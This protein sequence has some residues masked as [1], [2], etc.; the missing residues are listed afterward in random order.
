VKYSDLTL[1]A[2]LKGDALEIRDAK[3]SSGSGSLT[4]KGRIRLAGAGDPGLDVE[5]HPSSFIAIRT[6]DYRS[7]LSGNLHLGGTLRHPV[8][9]GAITF[10]DTDVYLT[11]AKTED[12]TAA[13]SVT[14]TPADYRMLEEAF[15]Y[16]VAKAPLPAQLF[17]DASQLDV[18]VVLG[19]N[20]WVRQRVAP[21]LAIQLTGSFQLTKAPNGEPLLVGRIAPVPGRGSVEQFARQFDLAGG[22]ILLNGDLNSHVLDVK[23]EY[24]VPSG[25]EETRSKV[26]V[27]LD[28]QGRLDQ[29]KLILSSEPP[30]DQ[31]DIISYI[32]T[33]QTAFSGGKSQGNKSSDAA[34]F[35][36]QV[37]MSGVTSRIED[38]AQQKV[39]VDVVE[40]RQDGVEGVTLIAGQYVTPE[41]YVG[42]RQPVGSTSSTTNKNESDFKTQYELNYEVYHWLLVNLQGETSKFKSF[43]RARRE[44]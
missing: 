26:V 30:L 21:R 29:L 38:L 2:E 10:V 34:T 11:S 16:T 6:R 43:I 19:G 7:T 22:E 23:T 24:K 20:T 42:F 12:Q 8:V 44:Y 36:T 18:K 9:S 15:G 27:H 31:A 40:V 37:A 1:G 5:V 39:G 17:Y 33:G 13:A 14:L 25:T 32:V 4:A 41:L 35:A 28:I 3:V